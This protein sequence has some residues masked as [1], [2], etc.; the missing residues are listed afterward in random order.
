[1]LAAPD[2]PTSFVPSAAEPPGRPLVQ[3]WAE[4]PP[5]AH[6][7][8]GT[9]YARRMATLA[10]TGSRAV[11][12]GIDAIGLRPDAVPD[13]RA[14]NGRLALR[15]GWSGTCRCTP[16]RRSRPACSASGR[17]GCARRR[18]RR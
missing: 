3:R 9:L 14:V 1:M 10:D 8:W 2:T 12:D 13:L 16:I 11:L 6:A 15:T 4:Y 7:V 18:R 5:E 17:S